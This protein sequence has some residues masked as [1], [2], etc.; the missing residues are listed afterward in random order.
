MNCNTVAEKMPDI[1]AG[2]LVFDELADCRRHIARCEACSD[3]MR[4]AEALASLKSRDTESPPADLFAAVTAR[5]PTSAGQH[6]DGRRFWMG[7][8]FGGAVAAS[9]FALALATGWVELPV[10]TPATASG[11]FIVALDEPRNMHVAIETDQALA[12][13]TI[14]VILAGNIELDGYAGQRE[15]TWNSDLAAGV[16]RLTLPVRAI[17]PAGGRLV[18]RLRHPES[19]QV[20]V[21]DVNADA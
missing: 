16:N 7:T 9:L 12:N 11:E 1:V 18:V 17:D 20:F 2:A 13:A 8:G 5:L 21:V 14:T 4:G 10:R 15:L 19:E 6:R 3:A